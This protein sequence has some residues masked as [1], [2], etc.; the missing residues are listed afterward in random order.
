MTRN[1]DGRKGD[2]NEEESVDESDDSQRINGD[3]NDAQRI[4]GDRNDDDRSGG[5]EL[6]KN[7]L[8]IVKVKDDA[9]GV[10]EDG[11]MVTEIGKGLLGITEDKTRI[12]NDR[13]EENESDY[14]ESEEDES[15][16]GSG[17]QDDDEQ[18]KN[19]NTSFTHRHCTFYS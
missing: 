16:D 17:E 15:K 12:S 13:K 9:S 18:G 6:A 1:N 4:S 2:D 14:D 8:K 11:D 7:G 3:R 19:I 5:D 10:Y